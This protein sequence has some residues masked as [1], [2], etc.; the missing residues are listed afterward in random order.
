MTN[1]FRVTFDRD[2]L[3]FNLHS[4][5]NLHSHFNLYFNFNLHLIGTIYTI[6]TNSVNLTLVQ[7]RSDPKHRFAKKKLQVT[8]TN[9]ECSVP[10]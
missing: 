6:S 1:L 9:I 7:S 4:L 5:H 2:N 10:S 3:Y 8:A